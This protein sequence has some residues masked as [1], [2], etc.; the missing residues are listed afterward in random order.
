MNSHQ[1]T[2]FENLYNHKKSYQK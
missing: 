1:F 2:T